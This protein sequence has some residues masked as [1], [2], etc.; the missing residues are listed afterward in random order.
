MCQR[1]SR[2]YADH[3]LGLS[4]KLPV[5]A[6]GLQTGMLLGGRPCCTGVETIAPRSRLCA[7]AAIFSGILLHTTRHSTRAAGVSRVAAAG[8]ASP[9]LRGA[10]LLHAANCSGCAVL[11]RLSGAELAAR[12]AA[13][14]CCHSWL[15]LGAP[16]RACCSGSLPL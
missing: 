3:F 16:M 14:R 9:L 8:A 4:P 1:R 10:G 7:T 11:K 2:C 6:A 13:R 15:G 12:A 5:I